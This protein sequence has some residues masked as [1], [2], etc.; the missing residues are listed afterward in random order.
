MST[1]LLG[2]F[3]HYEGASLTPD[4]AFAKVKELPILPLPEPV[5]ATDWRAHVP[6]NL[7]E[8][9]KAL[10]DGERVAIFVMARSATHPYENPLD[11]D[12]TSL[13]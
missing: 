9:W 13:N 10:C 2:T 8:G 3:N 7:L 11:C 1:L 4:Q 6:M 5:P 12:D